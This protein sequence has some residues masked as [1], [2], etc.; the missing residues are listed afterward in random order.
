VKEERYILPILNTRKANWIGH[1]CHRNCRVKHAVE[2]KIGVSID[3]AGRLR[4]RRQK[5]V[6]NVKEKRGYW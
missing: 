3:V 4:R 6:D 1:I 5:L 2:T